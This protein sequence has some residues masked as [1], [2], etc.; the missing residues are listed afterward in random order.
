[1]H[2]KL[3]LFSN[4]ISHNHLATADWIQIGILVVAVVAL[5]APLYYQLY[6]KRQEKTAVRAALLQEMLANMHGLFNEGIERPFLFKVF[7]SFLER[8]ST[9]IKNESEFQRL[10]SLYTELMDYRAVT[11]KYWPPRKDSLLGVDILVTQKQVQTINRFLQY[12]GEKLLND[13]FQMAILEKSRQ[14]AQELRNSKQEEWHKILKNNI[15]KI[16]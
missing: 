16:I 11:D 12:F 14:D 1:M 4:M 9:K 5:I 13:K 7:E 6:S 15:K 3:L 2:L 8:L 10:I